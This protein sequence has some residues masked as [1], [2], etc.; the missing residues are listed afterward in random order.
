VWSQKN[1]ALEISRRTTGTAD[2][3]A[4]IKRKNTR[5][6]GEKFASHEWF[7]SGTVWMYRLAERRVLQGDPVGKEIV[8]FVFSTKSVDAYGGVRV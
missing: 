4:K 1:Q 5:K 2:K 6:S 8:F 7:E 3:R